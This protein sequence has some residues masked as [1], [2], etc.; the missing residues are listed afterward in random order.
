MTATPVAV[1]AATQ[2]LGG[3][4]SG[5]MGKVSAGVNDLRTA[6]GKVSWGDSRIL[7]NVDSSF[8]L[9][10]RKWPPMICSSGILSGMTGLA[11]HGK[12]VF[13]PG[14]SS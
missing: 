12:K 3:V 10:Q 4:I 13:W 14:S 6:S 1:I 7:M 5:H 8:F 2:S 11:A 9:E